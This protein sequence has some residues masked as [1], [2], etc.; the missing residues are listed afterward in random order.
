MA[1]IKNA[2]GQSIASG[3]VDDMTAK[4]AEMAD[5]TLTLELAPKE[6]RDMK[7]RRIDAMAGDTQ[8]LLGTTSDAASL[9]LLGVIGLMY[10]LTEETSY[11]TYR[12]RLTDVLEDLAPGR[13]LRAIAT[14][15]LDQI[16]AGSIRVPLLEKGFDTV[17]AEI[18][19]RS[20]AVAEAL[21]D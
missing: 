7:R 10:A 18:S 1:L 12:R 13:D 4:L 14:D 9:A 2:D 21:E 5:N 20:T 17:L 19:A 11:S 3:P 6:V 16:K 15:F 8:S